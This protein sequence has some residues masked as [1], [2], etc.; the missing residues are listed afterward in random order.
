M[1]RIKRN[2]IYGVYCINLSIFFGFVSVAQ[3]AELTDSAVLDGVA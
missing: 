1:R 2:S 3:S